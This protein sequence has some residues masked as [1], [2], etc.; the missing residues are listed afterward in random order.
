[1][2]GIQAHT[3]SI[4]TSSKKTHLYPQLYGNLLC[5]K[6]G[7]AVLLLLLCINCFGRQHM[8]AIGDNDDSTRSIKFAQCSHCKE[9][10]VAYIPNSVSPRKQLVNAYTDSL[11]KSNDKASGEI[12]KASIGYINLDT[13]GATFAVQG[14]TKAKAPQ[15]E[16]RIKQDNRI[17]LVPWSAFTQFTDPALYKTGPNQ[18]SD[19][20]MAYIGKY[21]VPFGHYITVDVRKKGTDTIVSSNTVCWL[22]VK[23][24]VL[25]VFPVGELNNFLALIKNQWQQDAIYMYIPDYEKA[26]LATLLHLTHNFAPNDNS[27]IFYL[28]DKVRSKKFIEYCVE[29]PAGTT[30]WQPNDFDYNFIWLKNLGPGKYI[31]HMRFTTQRQNVSGYTFTIQ[32]AWYQTLWFKIGIDFLIGSFTCFVVVLFLLRAKQK[33]LLAAQ[34]KNAKAEAKLGAIRSQLNPHFIFNALSSIQGLVNKKDIPAANKYLGDFGDLMRDSLVAKDT[35]YISVEREIRLL[36]TYLQL[37]QL[38]F[39]FTYTVTAEEAL[40]AFEINI[41]VLLLQP[42]VENAVKHGVSALQNAGIIKVLFTAQG[43]D[44]VVSIAD[45]GGGF[46]SSK[47]NNGF[48]ISLTQERIALLNELNAGKPIDMK[49]DSSAAGTTVYFYFKNWL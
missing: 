8:L 29:G 1:M 20:E 44:M 14:I 19:P 22:N 3:V 24:K 13:A 39:N 49:M 23:P 34:L 41:P 43:N 21:T 30:A 10:I 42:I 15:F 16:Y 4:Q 31:L 17:E 27:L 36:D 6:K 9:Y 47:T 40:P 46:S 12:K 11:V 35:E 5:M 33:R 7:L 26:H 2:R 45:N 28:D 18:E 25:G 38:R 37:E 32:A 48:G